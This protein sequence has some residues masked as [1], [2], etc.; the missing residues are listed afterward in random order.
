MWRARDHLQRRLRRA[1]EGA[2]VRCEST[3]G[4]AAQTSAGGDDE[5]RVTYEAVAS[6]DQS[7]PEVAVF[8]AFQPF[9]SAN[10]A[11]R[12]CSDAEVRAVDMAMRCGWRAGQIGSLES[13]QKR[14]VCS[15]QFDNTCHTVRA[16][17][18]VLQMAGK[19]GWRDVGV[20]ICEGE[21]EIRGRYVVVLA[22]DVVHPGTAGCADIGPGDGEDDTGESGECCF[23]TVG[24]AIGA[25]IVNHYNAGTCGQGFR[26]GD[27]RSKAAL[28][29]MAL[30]ASGDDDGD[31]RNSH[32]RNTASENFSSEYE[33]TG[34]SHSQAVRAVCT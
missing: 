27:H 18:R 25:T 13:R 29:Q 31:V 7:G 22:E 24:G 17:V 19:P 20:S 15:V 16:P 3:A 12:G 1:E 6:G 34:T 28:Y 11:V 32:R 2:E 4:A 26:S 33:L 10:L 21:P 30:V 5:L 23:G 14:R 8:A 9:E